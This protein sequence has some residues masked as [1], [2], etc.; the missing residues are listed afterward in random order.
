MAAS[1]DSDS[2]SLRGCDLIVLARVDFL[3]F[4]ILMFPVLHDGKEMIPAPYVEV[5]A[6]GLM[7]TTRGGPQRLIYNLPPG[8]M[9]SLLISILYTAWR[10]GMNPSE[11]IICASYS[12]DLAHQLSRLTR[13]VM[14]S[15]RYRRI[16]P[17]TA[18]DKK[19]QDSLTTTKGG[20]RYA[21]SVT[22]PIAGFRADLI[23]IDDPMQPNEIASENAKQKLRDWYSGVVLQ[24]LL[25]GGVIVVVMH[26]LA[27]DD[28]TATLVESGGWRQFESFDLFAQKLSRATGQALYPDAVAVGLVNTAINRSARA[29]G[30][31]GV[32]LDEIASRVF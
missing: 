4:A 13:Q 14:Q 28:L 2:S 21:T 11:R 23:V 6:E 12:D 15:S 8:H 22:G 19:A 20:Q 18:L 29:L 24:R 7:N 26:R 30:K 25:P 1:P 17:G 10:L 31:T 16:F 27:P 3:A 9:K 32:R 5:I